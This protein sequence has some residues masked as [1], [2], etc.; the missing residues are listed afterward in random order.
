MGDGLRTIRVV[1]HD[2]SL[3]ASVKNVYEYN[4]FALPF[5]GSDLCG[6]NGDAPADLCARWH[7]V[8][9]LFPFAR[10]HN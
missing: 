4:L 1:S 6:F 3:I 10:N 7:Q 8:G 2:D 9:T 5:M